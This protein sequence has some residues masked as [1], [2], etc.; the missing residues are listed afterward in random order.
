[1]KFIPEGI[2]K[3]RNFNSYATGHEY[4]VDVQNFFFNNFFQ[5][6]VPQSSFAEMLVV[7]YMPYYVCHNLCNIL[8]YQKF[9][10]QMLLALSLEIES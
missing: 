4:C 9:Q 10:V 5:N 1:L 3:L 8:I 2:Y 7:P 6:F